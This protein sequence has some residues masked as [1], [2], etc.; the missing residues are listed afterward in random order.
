VALG[1]VTIPKIP[2]FNNTRGG[3]YQP[4]MSETNNIINPPYICWRL[5][6]IR[7]IWVIGWVGAGFYR[8]FVSLKLSVKPA[9]TGH[10]RGGFHQ[11]SMPETNNIINPPPPKGKSAMVGVDLGYWLGGGGFL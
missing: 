4:F 3:F 10:G 5:S 8:L 9:P 11:L 1:F 6:N 2:E 7:L